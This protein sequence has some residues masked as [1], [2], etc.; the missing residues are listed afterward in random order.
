S[1]G[2][3]GEGQDILFSPI[4]I[5]VITSASHKANFLLSYPAYPNDD[6]R[7]MNGGRDSPISVFRKL[8]SIGTA[9]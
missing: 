8:I 6:F 5:G 3:G 1:G 7:Y 4:P 9:A 2:V